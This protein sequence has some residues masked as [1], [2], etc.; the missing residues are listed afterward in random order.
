MAVG[1]GTWARSA[2]EM[3]IV[4]AADWIVV[5]KK[6]QEIGMST[7]ADKLL[8]MGYDSMACFPD[9]SAVGAEAKVA[10]IAD[11]LLGITLG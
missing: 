9:P 3:D 2:T 1:R 11:E 8:R 5:K 4:G 10:K 7:H 6:L